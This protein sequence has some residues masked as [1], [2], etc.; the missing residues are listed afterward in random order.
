MKALAIGILHRSV[1]VGDA[2][3]NDILGA[4]QLLE[5]MGFKPE[6]VCEFPH[7]TIRGRQRVSIDLQPKRIR[8]AYD[9]LIYHHSVDW[10]DGEKI[11]SAYQGPIVAKYHCVTPPNFFGGYSRAYEEVC[12]RG[13]EQTRRLAA[14]GKIKLWLADSAHNARELREVGVAASECVV[15]APFNRCDQLFLINHEAVY[16]SGHPISLLF[17]GRRSPNKGHRHLLRMMSSY[18]RLYSN[19]VRLRVVG[20]ADDQLA[21]YSDELVRLARESGVGD[22]VEWLSHVSD[23][24]VDALFRS[25]HVYV[26]ASEHEGFCVPIIEAQAVGMPLLTLG[27]TACS[28]TAGPNQIVIPQP[29]TSEDYDVMAGL[30]HEIVTNH[31]LR[32]RVVKAGF[33]NVYGRFAR[34]VIENAFVESISPMLS[35]M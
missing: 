28:E 29:A 12:R 9:V 25:S 31:T 6:I 5:R 10:P 3:G 23:E 11:L 1:I 21:R 33:R 16:E 27:T 19:Q 17:V 24:R 2:I 8:D 30:L 22:N 35:E 32:D 7:E 26:N 15:V 13:R 18:V 34:E 14:S 20:A 4:Y